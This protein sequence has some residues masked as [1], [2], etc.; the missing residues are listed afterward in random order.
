MVDHRRRA[1]PGYQRSGFRGRFAFEE[2]YDVAHGCFKFGHSRVHRFQSVFERA[3]SILKRL[4]FAF[5]DFSNVSNPSRYILNGVNETGRRC[6]T[7]ASKEG[8]TTTGIAWSLR[9]II[10]KRIVHL[11]H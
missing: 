5:R 4:L 9:N 1:G 6:R 11:N 10:S 2:L 7:T 8:V 3:D